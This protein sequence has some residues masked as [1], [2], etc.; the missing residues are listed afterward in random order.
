MTWHLP[1][2]FWILLAIREFIIRLCQVMNTTLRK[3]RGRGGGGGFQDRRMD[4]FLLH[5]LFDPLLFSP[6]FI[7]K[8]K[9]ATKKSRAL[10]DEYFSSFLIEKLG[11]FCLRSEQ[12][13]KYA[14][15][16]GRIIILKLPVF[17]FFYW[18]HKGYK[19]DKKRYS[20]ADIKLYSSS[21]YLKKNVI[22]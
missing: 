20:G 22:Q 9:T 6:T 11:V 16:L 1:V 3:R 8:T 4:V 15:S 19:Y 18:K 14:G 21:S 10:R 7:E 5:A 17:I 13:K 2:I 12:K